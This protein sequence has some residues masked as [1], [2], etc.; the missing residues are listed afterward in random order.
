MKKQ[1][2]LVALLINRLLATGADMSH[3]ANNFYSSDS[4]VMEK[5]RSTTS[6]AHEQYNA[7]P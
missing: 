6:A 4:L 7:G 3:A 5:S 2:A 1:L